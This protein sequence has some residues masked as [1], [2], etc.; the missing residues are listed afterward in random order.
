VPT[1]R[2]APTT[3]ATAYFVFAEA[4][5]NA[6]KYAYAERITVRLVVVGHALRVEVVDDGIGGADESAGSGLQGLRARVEAVG[7]TLTV[8]SP[9]RRGTRVRAVIPLGPDGAGPS[10]G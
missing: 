8:D 4:V 3:E 5:A 6:Q 9:P 1:Q 10:A 7:G 2:L